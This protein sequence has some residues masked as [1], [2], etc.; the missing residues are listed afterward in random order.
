M[1]GF[2]WEPVSERA[3]GSQRHTGIQ[4]TKTQLKRQFTDMHP[5]SRENCMEAGMLKEAKSSPAC[6]KAGCGLGERSLGGWGGSLTSLMV[7]CG[8]FEGER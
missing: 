3:S 1:L 8:G 5:V 7:E 4:F 6:C 2:T